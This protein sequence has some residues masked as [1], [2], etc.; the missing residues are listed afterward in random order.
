MRCFER[1]VMASLSPDE[2]ITQANQVILATGQLNWTMP[3]ALGL[4]MKKSYTH[5]LEALHQ[6][7]VEQ[8][9]GQMAYYH[10]LVGMVARQVPGKHQLACE[11]YQRALDIEP[12]RHDTL[13]NLA[14]LI[15]G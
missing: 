12:D 5:A 14:N 15:K 11:A 8:A 13:Y 4:W 1:W 10:T 2:A 3:L 9:C 6:P 7:G